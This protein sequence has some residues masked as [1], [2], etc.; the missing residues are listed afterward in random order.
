MTAA[1]NLSGGA[2]WDKN[3]L[4]VHFPVIFDYDIL[5]IVLYYVFSVC[6]LMNFLFKGAHEPA[7]ICSLQ[8]YK[9]SLISLKLEF[10]WCG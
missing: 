5:H 4:N 3:H 8:W 2:I 10:C 9:S 7:C 6:S 1:D